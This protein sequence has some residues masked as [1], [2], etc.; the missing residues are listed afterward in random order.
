MWVSDFVKGLKEFFTLLLENK[1]G[2]E[3][4]KLLRGREILVDMNCVVELKEQMRVDRTEAGQGLRRR[5]AELY[6]TSPEQGVSREFLETLNAKLLTREQALSTEFEDAKFVAMRHS[7]RCRID[8]NEAVLR[9]KRNGVRMYEWCCVDSLDKI[10]ASPSPELSALLETR[11]VDNIPARQYFYE[12][13]EIAF[14][15]NTVSGL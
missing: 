2:A 9:T 6:A 11:F 14:R 13:C 4:R 15:D 10:R 5:H 12:D 7:L 3:V 8:Y 1:T